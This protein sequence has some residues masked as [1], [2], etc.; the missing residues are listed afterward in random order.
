MVS[1]IFYL[2][3]KYQTVSKTT[4]YIYVNRILYCYKFITFYIYFY[5]TIPLLIF[6]INE[7]LITHHKVIREYV[8]FLKILLIK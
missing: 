3:K 8:D 6:K 1:V 5:L 7:V 2:V 4:V